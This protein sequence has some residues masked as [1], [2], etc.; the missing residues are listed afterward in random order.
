M[1]HVI[2]ALAGL[3]YGGLFALIKHLIRK[4]SRQKR[5]ETKQMYSFLFFSM[6][7]NIFTL[8]SIYFLRNWLPWSFMAMLIA[9]ALTLSFCGKLSALRPQKPGPAKAGEK[10]E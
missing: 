4:S 6:L 8:L 1:T 9:A 2:G 5:D 3:L 7:I 10:L